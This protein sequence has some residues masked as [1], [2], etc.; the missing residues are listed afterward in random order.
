MVY[1]KSSCRDVCK[2]GPGSVGEEFIIIS[3]EASDKEKSDKKMNLEHYIDGMELIAQFARM[4][5]Y[6]TLDG[7]GQALF[8]SKVGALKW[9]I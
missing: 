9:L 5:N 2:C 6:D 4:S 1:F 8:R 7:S 3:E